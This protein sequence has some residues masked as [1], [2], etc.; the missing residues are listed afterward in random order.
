MIDHAYAI[1]QRLALSLSPLSLLDTA[2]VVSVS[3]R[4]LSLAYHYQRQYANPV[5]ISQLMLMAP[6]ARHNEGFLKPPD[7]HHNRPN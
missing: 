6:Q 1:S 4:H 3:L 7:R 2:T 5:D